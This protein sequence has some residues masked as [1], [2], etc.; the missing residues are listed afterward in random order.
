MKNLHSV[1]SHTFESY[2]ERLNNQAKIFIRKNDTISSE[3][4]GKNWG[5]QDE[6]LKNRKTRIKL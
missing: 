3:F 6:S 1:Y 4:T 2:Y 5:E